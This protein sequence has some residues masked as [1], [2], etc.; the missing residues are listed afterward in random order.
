ML[1]RWQ[2]KPRTEKYVCQYCGYCGRHVGHVDD[3]V[4]SQHEMM[5]WYECK[6]CHKCHIR[7]SGIYT[8][9]RK[10]HHTKGNEFRMIRDEREIEALRKITT[11]ECSRRKPDRLNQL[12]IEN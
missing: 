10:V 11:E 6:I 5:N 4:N 3:H 1:E 8:H 9:L 7:Y 12:E 2:F